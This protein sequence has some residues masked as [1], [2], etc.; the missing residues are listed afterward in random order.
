[1]SEGKQEV[2]TEDILAKVNGLADDLLNWRERADQ[3]IKA[4]GEIS[5]ETKSTIATLEKKLDDLHVRV[6]KSETPVGLHPA[7][8]GKSIGHQFIESKAYK[9]MIQSGNYES[10]RFEVK[11]IIS[12]NLSSAGDLI[13]PERVPGIVAAPE[14]ALRIRNLLAP[15]NTTSNAIEYIEETLFTNAAAAVAESVQGSVVNKPE[16]TLRFDKKVASV[17]TYAHWI[18]AS[19]QVIADTPQLQ[20]YINERLTYGLKLVEDGVLADALIGAATAYDESL[21]TVLGIEAITRIDKI[22][23]AI[24][25]ARQAQYPVSGIVI[26]PVDWAAMEL[27]KDTQER[28]IWVSVVDGGTAR[29]WRVPVVES[30]AIEAGTFLTGAFRLGAQIWDR[31]GVSVRVSEHHA[32]YFIQNTVA[33]LAEERFGLT[34]Y[35]PQA[36]VYGSFSSGS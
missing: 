13:V 35:R 6:E 5:K 1:M 34:I 2:K 11:E 31:E 20:S 8:L 36:F 33:I 10:S 22:R 14:Q 9:D 16:S 7:T 29:L 18:P 26:N 4:A 17:G 12:S 19:R 15:G 30:D 24:L 3:D 27:L 21:E 23:V 28:Y 25:Q 32:S